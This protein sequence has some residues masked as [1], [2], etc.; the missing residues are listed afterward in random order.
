MICEY[1]QFIR[2]LGLS[3]P[4]L[5]VKLCATEAD[6]PTAAVRP[7]RDLKKHYSLCQAI[8]LARMEK[9]IIAMT[10]EDEW[11]WKPLIGFGGVRVEED[12]AAMPIIL[13]NCGIPNRDQAQKFF[14]SFPRLP[15]GAVAALAIGPLEQMAE[16]ADVV[17]LYCDNTAQARW[18]VGAA[19]YVTGKNVQTELDYIDSCVYSIVPTY[20]TGQCRVTIPD[21]GEMSRACCKDT[22]IIFS[23]PAVIFPDIAV[24]TVKKLKKQQQRLTKPD[25]SPRSELRMV[26]DFPRPQFYNRLFE[27]WGL[28]S[29]A[30]VLWDESDR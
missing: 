1:Q 16:E 5:A 2:M 3:V 26:A 7:Y 24:A 17:L 9:R 30:P 21:P 15:Y 13:E 20:L 4:P 28:H 18:L 29:D 8:A 27:I 19:K 25:G 11:C 14:Q 6:I 23:V 12:N 22:E 10:P